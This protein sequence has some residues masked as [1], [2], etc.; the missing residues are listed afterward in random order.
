MNQDHTCHDTD[1][2]KRR[3]DVV[4]DEL[5]EVSNRVMLDLK[6]VNNNIHQNLGASSSHPRF[7]PLSGAAPHPPLDPLCRGIGCADGA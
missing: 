3:D 2:I 6:Q 1:G 5:P 7:C 4:I